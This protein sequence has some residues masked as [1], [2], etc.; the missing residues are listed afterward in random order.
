MILY[1]I[2]YMLQSQ[3][4]QLCDI[5]KIIKDLGTDNVI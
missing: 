5:E 4:I 3:V 2:L 1:V